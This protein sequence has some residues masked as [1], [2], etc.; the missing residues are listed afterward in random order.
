M[1]IDGGYTLDNA[2]VE[3]RRRLSV[4]EAA[5]DPMTIGNLEEI[6][7]RPGWRCLEVGAGGGS[8]ARWLCDRVGPT[9]R[10]TAVDLDTRFVEPDAP[11]NL[12]IHQC[13]VTETGVPGGDYDLIHTR[14]VLLHVPK[15]RDRIVAEMVE[16]LAPGGWI[17]HEEPDADLLFAG[18]SDAW[19]EAWRSVLPALEQVGVDQR[20]GRRLPALLVHAGLED[21]S[22]RTIG[23]WFRG[24]SVLAQFFQL[25]LD[26]WT[27]LLTA[28]TDPD[29]A[30]AVIEAVRAELDDPSS[31]L[32]FSGFVCTRGRR[33]ARA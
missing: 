6:G 11:A 23:E 29:Q 20:Y 16:K 4:L 32:P 19:Q 13:D 24:R 26:Q 18:E 10:V 1:G 31:I 2:W 14:A 27:P 30:K 17:L 7:V 28:A 5:F 9:G 12:E 8:I 25:T 21:V 33:G 15:G 3:A 22:A